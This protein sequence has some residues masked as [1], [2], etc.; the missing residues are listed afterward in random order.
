[1][2]SGQ[3]NDGAPTDND[4]RVDK[5]TAIAD[6]HFF[7]KLLDKLQALGLEIK[8]TDDGKT[9]V[10]SARYYSNLSA[11]TRI[12]FWGM[13]L[14]ISYSEVMLSVVSCKRTLNRILK[15]TS[16][17]H[18]DSHEVSNSQVQASKAELQA[19]LEE[20][21]S[22]WEEVVPV[23]HMAVEKTMLE[24]ILKLANTKM[25]AQNYQNAIIGSYVGWLRFYSLFLCSLLML[26]RSAT[27]YHT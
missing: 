3:S 9:L 14:L 26:Y 21:N 7:G 4:Q 25:E 16:A 18:A 5:S 13:S 17:K 8:V 11:Q 22:L 27:A 24:P 10:K 12:P 19:L 1:L 15:E 6:D 23:A 2:V 20:T